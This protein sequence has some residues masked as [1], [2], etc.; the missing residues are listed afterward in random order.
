MAAFSTKRAGDIVVVVP[1]SWIV[2]FAHRR[3]SRDGRRGSVP[4]PVTRHGEPGR[5]RTEGGRICNRCLGGSHAAYRQAVAG[6]E[7]VRT[8]DGSDGLAG[9]GAEG[10]EIISRLGCRAGG[11]DDGA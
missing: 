1:L 3:I 6:E 2:G 8:L 9:V 11:A 10:E 5:P 7:I 4:W